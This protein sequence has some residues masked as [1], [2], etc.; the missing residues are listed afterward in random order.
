MTTMDEVRAGSAERPD[1]GGVTPQGVSDADS[2]GCAIKRVMAER[3]D[4]TILLVDSS[5]YDQVQ[6]ERVCALPEVNA[7]VSEAAPPE[8]LAASLKAAG[9]RVVIA[10]P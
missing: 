2:Q 1:S 9:V 3:A 6:F 8:R 4:E 7:L 5:K 10:A